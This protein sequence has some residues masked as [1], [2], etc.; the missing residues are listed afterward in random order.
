M[1]QWDPEIGRLFIRETWAGSKLAESHLGYTS[2]MRNHPQ[3]GLPYTVLIEQIDGITKPGFNAV[4]IEY[5]C[6]KDEFLT[7]T[8]RVTRRLASDQDIHCLL[9]KW[10][11]KER[12]SPEDWINRLRK[13]YAEEKPIL[14]QTEL[15]RLHNIAQK[16][17]GHP[18]N[19]R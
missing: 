8:R 5:T 19:R 3:A 18:L 15:E 14:A 1:F 13:I 7:E 16:Y 9:D 6:S 4:T 12:L 2:K 17:A 11:I 10:D